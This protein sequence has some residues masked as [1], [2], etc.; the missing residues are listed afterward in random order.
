PSACIPPPALLAR[1]P[2]DRTRSPPLTGRRPSARAASLLEGRRGRS[3]TLSRPPPQP[4]HLVPPSAVRRLVPGSFRSLSCPWHS[5]R[6][7]LALSQPLVSCPGT[8]RF[9]A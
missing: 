8:I 1:A 5:S 2:G 9:L 4:R 3:G 7:W 6:G